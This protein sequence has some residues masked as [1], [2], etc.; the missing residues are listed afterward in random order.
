MDTLSSESKCP[1]PTTDYRFNEFQNVGTHALYVTCVEILALPGKPS[2]ISNSL[3]NVVLNNHK[4]FPRQDIELWINATALIFT[5]LPDS[6]SCVIM[7]RIIEFMEKPQF[8][9]DKNMSYLVDFKNSHLHINEYDISYL[10]ALSHAYWNHGSLGQISTLPQF[11]KDRIKP[12]IQTEEQFIFVCFL[13]GPFLYRFSI[14]R[15]R[16]VMDITIELYEMLEIIDKKIEKF[17]HMD[18]ICDLLYHIKCKPLLHF[19]F[20]NSN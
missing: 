9:Y 17:Q 4:Y 7:D 12:I 16:C 1:F 13:I 10:I 18:M 15:T 5:A 19:L 14:E 3:I 20:C 8:F 2:D 11:I 6:Y